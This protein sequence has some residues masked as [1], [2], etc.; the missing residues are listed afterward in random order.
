MPGTLS[1]LIFAN[2]TGPITDNKLTIT[3]NP[4]TSGSGISVQ[5][6]EVSNTHTFAGGTGIQILKTGE[7]HTIICTQPMV[8]VSVG[9]NTYQPGQ[10]TGLS[11]GQGSTATLAGGQLTI[12]GFGASGDVVAAGS[13]ISIA[14]SNGVK[15]ISNLKPAPQIILDG[16]PYSPTSIAFNDFTTSVDGAH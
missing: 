12:G 10:K 13:N 1:E 11:F 6:S 3:Q 8:T 2:T 16:V 7:I 14:L 9:G 15:V 4:I 5:G